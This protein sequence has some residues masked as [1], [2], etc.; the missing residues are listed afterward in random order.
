MSATSSTG[1]RAACATRM[2]AR[3][4]LRRLI[5]AGL[6]APSITTRSYSA[7]RERRAVS[8]GGQSAG[9]RSRHERALSSRSGFPSTTTWLRRSPSG[10]TS[11]GFIR[12]SGSTPAASAWRYWA[13][14]ISPPVTTRALF[15]MFCPLN[16]ATRIPRRASRRMS[17][18]VTRLFPA[19]LETPCTISAGTGYPG[20]RRTG[21]T[22]IGSLPSPITSTRAL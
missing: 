15:D 4:V 18:V 21:M 10:F 11:T 7:R 6:P 1:A 5:S 16:G 3:S 22:A 14:P 2:F 13:T 8:I 19:Q 17:A 9:P 12:T 20:R